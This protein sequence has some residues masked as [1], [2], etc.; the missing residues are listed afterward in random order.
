VTLPNC[1]N[2]GGTLQ[3]AETGEH[4]CP[5]C[6]LVRVQTAAQ[7]RTPSPVDYIRRFPATTVLIAINVLVF[8]VMVVNHVS[9]AS[10]TTADIIQWGG[11]SGEKIFI[12]DQWW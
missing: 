3:I 1:P 6:R 10:P 7:P 5:E 12:H 8:L 4:F 9:A 2:C 11:D